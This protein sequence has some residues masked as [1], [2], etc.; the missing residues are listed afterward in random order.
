MRHVCWSSHRFLPQ[1]MPRLILAPSVIE[2]AGNKPKR[3]EEY[4]GRVNTGHESVSVARMV[5]PEGWEEPG[6]RPEF[7]ELTVVLEGCLVVEHAGGSL[8]VRAGQAVLA[9]PGEHSHR[10]VRAQSW[11]GD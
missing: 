9:E 8:E 2:S 1:S 11:G 5:S 3:I 4:A 6:Q 10:Q 7:E